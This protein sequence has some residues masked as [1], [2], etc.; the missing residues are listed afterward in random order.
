MR[1]GEGSFQALQSK[2]SFR[3][4]TPADVSSFLISPLADGS[5]S[6]GK[7]CYCA[8]S[9]LLSLHCSGSP[10]QWPYLW[11]HNRLRERR[12]ILT[13]WKK[14]KLRFPLPAETEE[15]TRERDNDAL[16]RISPPAWV[17]GWNEV[18][19]P[20]L[21]SLPFQRIHCVVPTVANSKK[22]EEKGYFHLWE[23]SSFTR[24]LSS[25]FDHNFCF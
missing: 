5:L 7:P 4:C 23:R 24:K 6:R 21:N 25:G 19:Y 14:R 12:L 22:G 13:Q 1:R 11:P 9:P 15:L 16:P 8:F 18:A 17:T 10:I 3:L 20:Y 2:L